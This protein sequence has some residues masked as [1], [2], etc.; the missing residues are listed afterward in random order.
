MLLIAWSKDVG[1][2][3]DK[4]KEKEIRMQSFDVVSASSFFLFLLL[5]ALRGPTQAG[6]AN[7]L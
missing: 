1:A 6:T 4:G 5:T 2:S 7:G 3:W